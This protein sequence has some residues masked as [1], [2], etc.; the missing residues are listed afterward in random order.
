VIGGIDSEEGED[1]AVAGGLSVAAV[2]ASVVAGGAVVGMLMVGE[3][4]VSV[5]SPPARFGRQL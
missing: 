2:V 4:A 5:L 3:T 1:T